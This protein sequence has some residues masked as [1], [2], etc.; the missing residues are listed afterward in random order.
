[1]STKGR[2]LHARR[3]VDFLAEREVLTHSAADNTQ[4]N[5]MGYRGIWSQYNQVNKQYI[6]ER[7]SVGFGWL[8]T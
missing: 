2:A 7:I 4:K 1:M 3:H 6:K 5:A 8:S